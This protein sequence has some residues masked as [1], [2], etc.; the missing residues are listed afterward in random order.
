MTST[1][2]LNKKFLP[3]SLVCICDSREQTPVDL[4]PL[5]V[6][7]GTLPTGD[8]SV[9]GLEHKIAIERK[10]LQDLV[11][12]VGRERERFD[13]NI[14][15]LLGYETRAII[16][17][18]GWASVEL[19]LYRGDVHPNAIMGSILGWISMGIPIIMAEDH[20]RAG[21]FISRI[22]YTAARRHWL[23]CYGFLEQQLEQ[24]NAKSMCPSVRRER[25]DGS[26]GLAEASEAV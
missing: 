18:S 7:R 14:Q 12:C 24:D 25:P 1:S 26:E 6:V 5:K 23:S 4:A 16:V 15:R 20:R 11:M 8:Y 9:Q 17:E 13:K 3:S 22:L 10:S 21:Q 2:K 19:K